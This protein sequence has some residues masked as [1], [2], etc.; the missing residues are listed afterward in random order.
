MRRA[1]DQRDLVDHE[2]GIVDVKKLGNIPVGGG[3]R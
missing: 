1:P 2:L 3:W